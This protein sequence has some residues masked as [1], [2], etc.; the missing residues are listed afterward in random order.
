MKD[1]LC[2]SALGPELAGGP[3]GGAGDGTAGPPGGP[4]PQD[5]PRQQGHAANGRD[6]GGQLGCCYEKS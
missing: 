1:R 4:G 6:S 2:Y 5:W 3:G